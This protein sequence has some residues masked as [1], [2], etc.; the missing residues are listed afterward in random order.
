M[1]IDTLLP[2]VILGEG[3]W[4]LFKLRAFYLIHPIRTLRSAFSGT[5][6]GSAWLSL[7]LA[8]AG[9]LGVGNI[10]GVTVAIGIGGAGSLFWMVLSSLFSAIIKYGEVRITAARGSKSGMI[11]VLRASFPHTGGAL[12]AIYASVALCLS[13][14]MGAAL[15][16][17]A[18]RGSMVASFGRVPSLVAALLAASLIP[19]SFM[20]DGIKKA[21]AIIIPLAAFC[22]TGLCL[23]VI[24]PNISE[25]PSVITLCVKDAFRIR[26]FSGGALGSMLSYAVTR[27]FS[28]GLLSNEAGA[29]TSSFSHNALPPEE[30]E[31]AG[32]FGIIEVAFDTVFLCTL[33]G[34]TVIIGRGEALG[35]EYDIGML[36]RIFSRYAGALGKP[37]LLFSILAFAISTVLCWY[38]YGSVCVK[39]LSRGRCKT[40]STL[41]AAFFFGAFAIGL[42]FDIAWLI[43]LTDILLLILTVLTLFAIVKSRN[44]ITPPTFSRSSV[45]CKKRR[46]D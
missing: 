41:F 24:L 39:E 7:M 19:L 18:I 2:L 46:N 30:A 25:L 26:S 4:L 15:Q 12:A 33:T 23:F 40:L 1:A 31:R 5:G 37:L 14:A 9:T 29:G 36:A 13:L 20:G 17:S 16:S 42:L 44:M 45:K 8:L 22:Y 43:P 11:G 21:V 35:A 38:Y 28:A 3:A 6:T 34:V 10:L 32:V 27:G